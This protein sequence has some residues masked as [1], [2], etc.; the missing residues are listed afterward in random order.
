MSNAI[1]WHQVISFLIIVSRKTYLRNK[2]SDFA[3]KI[4]FTNQSI[5]N[6]TYSHI[7]LLLRN[8]IAIPNVILV[9]GIMIM[10]EIINSMHF[11]CFSSAQGHSQHSCIRL[12]LSINA[13][14][15]TVHIIQRFHSCID[16]QVRVSLLVIHA[17]TNQHQETGSSIDICLEVSSIF[18]FVSFNVFKH[19]RFT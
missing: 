17:V 8:W 7:N 11:R 13:N 4:A 18:I 9:V 2:K 6:G 1:F 10:T 14:K 16:L 3:I 15:S 5:T 12:L 19:T